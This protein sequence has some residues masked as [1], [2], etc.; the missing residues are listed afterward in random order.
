MKPEPKQDIPRF[1]DI[2]PRRHTLLED[3]YAI[4]I[5]MVFVV[6]GVSLMKAAGIITSGIA[7]IALLLSYVL[8][9][10]VGT[11]FT[12]ANVPFFIFA[13]VTMGGRFAVKSTIASVGVSI[14]LAMMPH[15][16]GISHI[17]PLFAAFAGGTLCG[18]G[19]LALARHGAGVGG[20]G[21]VTLWLYRRR[22]INAGYS[23]VCID[24]VTLL[25]ST[26]VMP[27]NLVGWSALSAVALSGM[28]MAWHR[29]GR[30]TGY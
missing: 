21:I 10:P 13:F 28:V 4:I 3:A 22:G 7:G 24:G 25:V 17:D 11:L 14:L 18:M 26:A 16:L 23:Q 15:A 6:T 27:M 19:V 8:P 1:D 5:G 29:P 30:Y 12:L 2:V 20:T 9:L